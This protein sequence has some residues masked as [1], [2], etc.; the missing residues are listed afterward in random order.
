MARHER[1]L[2]PL[3]QTQK[4]VPAVGIDDHD[5]N[6]DRD[7]QT[8][9]DDRLGL[10]MPASPASKTRAVR[11]VTEATAPLAVR[12]EGGWLAALVDVELSV[13]SRLIRSLLLAVGAADGPRHDHEGHQ[14]QRNARIGCSS[15]AFGATPV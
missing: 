3:A 4:L 1:R 5:D 10:S 14:P 11:P 9:C 15:M 2:P 6:E 8:D 13:I 12:T 7:R